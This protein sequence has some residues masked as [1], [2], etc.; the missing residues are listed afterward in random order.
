MGDK[1]Q[2]W[3]MVRSVKE[4]SD[5]TLDELILHVRKLVVVDGKDDFEFSSETFMQAVEEDKKI[6][7]SK[8]EKVKEARKKQAQ[9]VAQERKG[10]EVLDS[11]MLVAHD[12]GDLNWILLKPKV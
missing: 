11:V 3:G 12:L 1:L 4:K 9:K 8:Q 7:K 2:P 5:V 10:W 6:V